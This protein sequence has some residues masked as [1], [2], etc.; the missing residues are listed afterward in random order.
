MNED[1]RKQSGMVNPY[2]STVE[3]KPLEGQ[4]RMR[5]E[6]MRPECNPATV[7]DGRGGIFTWY[8]KDPIVEFSMLY[9]SPGKVRGL[10]YHPE[11]IETILAVDGQAALVGVDPNDPEKKEEVVHLSKG[12][13]VRIPIGYLHTFYAITPFTFMALLNKKWD[14]SNPPIVQMGD[15]LAAG[16]K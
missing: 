1:P 2:G 16:S 15:Q 10:H 13:A 12:V 11:F 14:D 9:V 5:F 6:V 7:K 8:P 4:A 3:T